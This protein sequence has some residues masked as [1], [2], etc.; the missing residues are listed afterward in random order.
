MKKEKVLVSW[1]GGKDSAFALYEIQRNGDYEIAALFS[2]ITKDYDRITMHG[3]RRVLL[4]E[5]AKAIGIPVHEVF[6]PKKVSNEEYNSIMEKEMMEAK[7]NGI[8]S[9]VFGDI[10]LEDVRK[11]REENL[12]KVSMRG[13]FPLWKRGSRELVT[14]FINLGFKAIVV[15]VDSN[16]L[17]KSFIGRT[18]DKKF[19]E[20]LPK[21]VDPAGENGEYHTFVYHG[22]M[23]KKE[24]NFEKGEIVFR[25]NRFYYLDLIPI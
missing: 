3:V 19:L 20:D 10:F 6:I 17:D 24:V 7:K 11:Y 8:S 5:Q 14:D 9:V 18:V 13:I 16:V 22:P 4:E 25:E 23:F 12:S 15:C 1:S 2:T 21:S